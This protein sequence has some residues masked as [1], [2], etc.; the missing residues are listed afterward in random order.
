MN[1]VAGTSVLHSGNIKF[2][3]CLQAV[4]A[5]AAASAIRPALW[6]VSRQDGENDVGAA[7]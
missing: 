7:L 3:G 6:L 2:E 1:F 4:A 5:V